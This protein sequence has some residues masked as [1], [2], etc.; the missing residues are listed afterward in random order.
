MKWIPLICIFFCS[1]FADWN[2]S[3]D[4]F[5]YIACA[6]VVGFGFVAENDPGDSSHPAAISLMSSG[7]T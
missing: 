5:D 7:N 4:R 3:Q 2:F 1:L 6:N